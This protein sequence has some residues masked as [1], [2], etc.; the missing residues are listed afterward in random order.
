MAKK[1]KPDETTTEAVGE[2]TETTP[3]KPEPKPEP[4]PNGKLSPAA[5]LRTLGCSVAV[6]SGVVMY[7]GSAPYCWRSGKALITKK[8]A[9]AGLDRWQTRIKGETLRV[10]LERENKG[11]K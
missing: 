2:A 7:H 4:K 6:A 1:T 9:K 11:G 10:R 5:W 3:K 8:Q